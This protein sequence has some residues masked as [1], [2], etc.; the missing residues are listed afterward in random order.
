M[1]KLYTVIWV[2]KI[3]GFFFCSLSI[4]S[5]ERS[6]EERCLYTKSRAQRVEIN[7]SKIAPGNCSTLLALLLNPRKYKDTELLLHST[8][9]FSAVFRIVIKDTG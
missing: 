9:T 2:S 8:L 1:I 4:E 3:S 7:I 6:P 5:R